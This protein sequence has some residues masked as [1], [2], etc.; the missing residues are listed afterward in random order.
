M[1]TLY[2]IANKTP[3]LSPNV[4]KIVSSDSVC[5][6][7]MM[8]ECDMSCSTQIVVEISMYVTFL[9][10]AQNR[11]KNEIMNSSVHP[12]HNRPAQSP[13]TAVLSQSI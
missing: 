9:Q 10:P 11:P 1:N 4:T 12:V 7:H 3:Y 6:M 8:I 2:I 13:V 5:P